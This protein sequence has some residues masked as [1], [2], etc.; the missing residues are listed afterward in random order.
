MIH[1]TGVCRKNFDFFADEAEFMRIA[2][3]TPR[4]NCVLDSSKLARAGVPMTEVHDAIEIALRK[5][6]TVPVLEAEVA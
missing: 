3:R 4:S 2:A 1:R 6:S 5:W